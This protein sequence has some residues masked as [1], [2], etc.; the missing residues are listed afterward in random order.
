MCQTG[1]AAAFGNAVYVSSCLAFCLLVMIQVTAPRCCTIH[2][3]LVWSLLGGRSG[4]GGGS[5]ATLYRL[6]SLL[7]KGVSVGFF[8][9][10]QW[11]L[12]KLQI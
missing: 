3:L 5:T 9:S 4:T 10:L 2:Y 11:L 8:H 7:A 1:P 6:T 12:M